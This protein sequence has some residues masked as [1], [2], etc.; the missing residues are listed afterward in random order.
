L[1]VPTSRRRAPVLAMRSGSRKP[2]PISTISPAADDDL[3][4]GG[5]AVVRE[6]ER[7]APLLTTS[8][9][10]A[11]RH[12][13]AQRGER[14][15]AAAGPAAVGDVVLDV[16]VAGGACDG[17]DA[18]GDSG[19]R[20]RLV[21]RTTPVALSTGRSVVAPRAARHGRVDHAL[22]ARAPGRARPGACT[23]AALTRSRRD[24]RPPSTSRGSASA[25]S[26]RGTLRRGSSRLTR[27]PYF[28]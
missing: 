5:Q 26:V 11:V 21:C 3:A 14:P 7:R 12:R 20:P 15:A 24:G 27:R 25:T 9:S 10:S 17:V 28:G 16:D 2:S 4:A 22:R 18:A 13:L 8:T 19:A 6:H 23:T 1:V